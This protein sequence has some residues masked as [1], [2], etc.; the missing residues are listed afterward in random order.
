[1]H[2]EHVL[3]SAAANEAAMR[4][5]GRAEIKSAHRL[6][7]GHPLPIQPLNGLEDGALHHIQ[8]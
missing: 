5:C 6:Y 7:D 3:A 2:A 8:T 1:M 4:R